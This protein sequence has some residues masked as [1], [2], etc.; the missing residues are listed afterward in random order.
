MSRYEIPPA[1]FVVQVQHHKC[2]IAK[3][4]AALQTWQPRYAKWEPVYRDICQ[5]T[6]ESI[7]DVQAR[8]SQFL[9]FLKAHGWPV[10]PSPL[11]AM[12]SVW[13]LLGIAYECGDEAAIA[14]KSYQPVSNS[15]EEEALRKLK[16]ARNQLE[17]FIEKVQ[18]L[19]ERLNRLYPDSTRVTLIETQP[20]QL[21]APQR[22]PYLHIVNES[23]E[24]ETQDRY[25]S[26]LC[27]QEALFD[28]DGGTED[29]HLESEPKPLLGPHHGRWVARVMGAEGAGILIYESTRKIA[30]FHADEAITVLACLV[31][32]ALQLLSHTDPQLLSWHQEELEVIRR[33]AEWDDEIQAL[34]TLL[35]N[36][37]GEK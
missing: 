12:R 13:N 33:R 14:V 35:D 26:F 22:H 3:A 30:F 1:E 27:E 29:Y 2:A 7:S 36:G 31:E 5:L 18:K 6:L 8:L 15:V 23:N 9:T 20:L 10:P 17:T 25:L 37:G 24:Q 28:P 19:I 34:I 21:L 4:L 16:K 11:P 32:E